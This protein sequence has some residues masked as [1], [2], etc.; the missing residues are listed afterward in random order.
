MLPYPHA[1]PLATE[2]EA[3]APDVVTTAP[4]SVSG[5][6]ATAAAAPLTPRPPAAAE[7]RV[8]TW[9]AALALVFLS[10]VIAEMLSGSTPPLLFIR[11]FARIVLPT[12]YGI[13]ALLIREIM[14]RRGLG[15][16]NALLLGAA[17]GIFQEA[18]MVQTWYTFRVPRSPSHTT[19]SYAIA[20][21][22][23][24]DWALNVTLYHAV[25]SITVPLI[26]IA[27]FF[28][29]QAALPWLGRKRVIALV[30][31]LLA[32]CGLLAYVVA[33]KQFAA[34]GYAGPPLPSYLLAVALTALLLLLGARVRFPDPQG[35][36]VPR[37]APRLWT[38]RLA[39]AGLI[40]CYFVI[41]GGILPATHLPGIT[42]L[43]AGVA[44]FALGLWRVRAWSARPG[45]GARHWLALG[46]GVV[47]F[48]VFP[49]GPLIEFVARQPQ[50]QGLVLADLLALAA[51]L[52]CDQRLKRR[53]R[54]PDAAA[55][56]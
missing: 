12:L 50:R 25:I 54:Q 24:W 43:L 19:G 39:I 38:V 42:G 37:H 26:L 20:F 51:L 21:G 14:V 34:D 46:T 56:G 28:P 52:V 48:F 23:R 7:R 17:F 55:G 31:W 53:A 10:P 40:V 9:P 15:W 27:V 36:R 5:V 45:W 29:R 35:G 1:A 47:L 2:P 33:F 4:L 3:P 22:I 11:P 6:A 18:L 32:L 41:I 13:S 49:W 30:I 44:V 8:R 16:G